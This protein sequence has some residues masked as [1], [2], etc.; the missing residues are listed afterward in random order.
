MLDFA[1]KLALDSGA[2]GDEDIA[3]VKAHGFDDEAVWTSAPSPPS[4]P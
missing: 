1:M 3:A 2:V 4:S